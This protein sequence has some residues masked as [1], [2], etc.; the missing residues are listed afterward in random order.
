MRNL[1]VSGREKLID[2]KDQIITW[3][4]KGLLKVYSLYPILLQKLMGFMGNFQGHVTHWILSLRNLKS[5]KF[6][7]KNF[8]VAL[9]ALFTPHI[10]KS[11]I[12]LGSLKPTTIVASVTFT[13]ISGLAAINIYLQGENIYDKMRSPASVKKEIKIGVRPDYYKK[14][15]K[16]FTIYHIKMPLYIE[17]IHNHKQVKI[18]FTLEPSNRYIKEYFLEKE[19]LIHDRLNL[20]VHPIVPDLPMSEEG[21]Q[22]LKDKLLLEI[23]LLIK[24]LKIKG[25]IKNVY[26]DSALAV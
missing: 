3:F 12:W 22:I 2:K 17:S 21:K 15:E 4:K 11:K 20:M 19:F 9:G 5:K 16:H 18:D 13:T 25:K 8:F 10:A 1:F 23:N 6:N 14:N 26:I 24:E 7:F